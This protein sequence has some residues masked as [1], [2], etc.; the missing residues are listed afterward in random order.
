MSFWAIKS[1]WIKTCPLTRGSCTSMK[2]RLFGMP[3]ARV[4]R[5]FRTGPLSRWT[6]T[7]QGCKRIIRW[8]RRFTSWRVS[9]TCPLTA[10]A[11]AISRRC[12]RH[13]WTILSQLLMSFYTNLRRKL[14]QPYASRHSNR[15]SNNS[16]SSSSKSRGNLMMTASTA[17]LKRMTL[18]AR[19]HFMGVQR[20]LYSRSPRF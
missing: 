7:T 14:L 5:Y 1:C 9:T 10:K 16:N 13:C 20:K 12:P 3:R 8:L 11:R 6:R 19:A 15:S 18:W 4:S 17:E 2:K